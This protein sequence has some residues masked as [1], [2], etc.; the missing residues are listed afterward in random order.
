LTDLSP[1]GK[2]L[3]LSRFNPEVHFVMADE[4]FRFIR[5]CAA[6][7]ASGGYRLVG[8]RLVIAR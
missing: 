3:E 2:L 7:G 8:V 5:Q 6:A 4:V 1:H